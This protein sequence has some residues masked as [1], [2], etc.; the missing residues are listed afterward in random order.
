MYFKIFPS[1]IELQRWLCGIQQ[2]IFLKTGE[3]QQAN[4]E[5]CKTHIVLYI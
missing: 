5:F 4:T 3:Y 2:N 1:K